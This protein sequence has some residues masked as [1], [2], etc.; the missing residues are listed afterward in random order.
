MLRTPK[1]YAIKQ[2]IQEDQY[3]HFGIAVGI[4][5]LL[6]LLDFNKTTLT[7]CSL[8]VNF[9]EFPCVPRGILAHPVFS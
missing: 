5:E 3:Y 7:I 4:K 1:T 2:I 6:P 9:D 8:Q